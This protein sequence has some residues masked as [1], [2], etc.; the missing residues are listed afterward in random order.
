MTYLL[1]NGNYLKNESSSEFSLSYSM[2]TAEVKDISNSTNHSGML[3]PQNLW[4][5]FIKEIVILHY[6]ILVQI[7]WKLQIM[8][9]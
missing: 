6:F 5:Y 9:E 8:F 2:K 1:Q 7:T 4:Y 3:Q